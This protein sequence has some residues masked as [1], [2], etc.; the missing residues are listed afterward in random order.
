MKK[1]LT[2][3]SGVIIAAA[4]F[5]SCI[6]D[7]FTTSPSDVLEFSVDTLNMGVIF[8]E[9]P[10]TTHRFVVY[11]RNSKAVSISNIAMQGPNAGLFRLNVDGFSG[12]DFS[13]VEIRANDSIFVFVAAT[14][15]AN[16]QSVPVDVDATLNFTTNGV[17]QQIIVRA[18]GRD[19]TRLRA[20][21]I[22]SDTRLTAN[23]PY[24]IFDS[25]VVAPEAT[26]T[27]DPGVELLFHDGA[28]MAVRGS[29]KA[30]G[31]VDKEI[32]FAGDRT[33]NV[34]TDVS[35]DIMS[36][37]WL[38]LFFTSTSHDNQMDYCHIR[39]T[40]YGVTVDGT[41]TERP[42]DLSMLNTRLRNSGDI[43]LQAFHANITA[44]GCEFAE[45]ANGCVYLQ[46]GA[47]IFNHCTFANYYLFSALGGPILQF[48][49]LNADSDDDSGRPYT[50]ADLSNC[51]IYGN[52]ADLSHG[53][54]TDTNIYLRRCLLK[55]DGTDDDHF[56]SC[57]WA[58][59]PLYYTV[60]SDYYF[61]Y[62]LRPDSP[63]IGAGDPVLT[64][65]QA[66]TD[67]YGLPRGT[68]PDLGAYVF[69]A[70]QE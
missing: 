20:L 14:I 32:S 19:V 23:H 26:L 27:I 38:G 47:H 64:L 55:S 28:Y 69:V 33:G 52:G 3:F 16:N 13:N 46:G 41:L 62:R 21:T 58:E 48:W 60:R 70:P 44:I 12:S 29:L 49:H 2:L 40:E 24:Q 43:V 1:Y 30:V 63:A 53:D 59:D 31:A 8:T 57:I 42:V 9:E 11:N 10:S 36:R 34:I 18:S 35:F 39:N 50:S 66:A 65:P 17:N 45:A 67:R 61:D 54:F 7:D 5:P 68:Q 6:D 25:L 15:P 56:I 22:T 37:Q 4:F 51:I